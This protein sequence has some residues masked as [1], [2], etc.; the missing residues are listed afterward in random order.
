MKRLVLSI[1]FGA[2]IFIIGCKDPTVT[3]ITTATTVHFSADSLAVY[4][5]EGRTFGNTDSLALPSEIAVSN[6]YIIVGDNIANR[7]LTIFARNTGEYIT[8]AGEKGEGPGEIQRVSYLDFKSDNDIGWVFDF[9]R[10][11]MHYVDIDSLIKSNLT[12]KTVSFTD[13]G[14][15]TSP[16]W[17]TADSIASGG[18]YT[19][20]KLALYSSDGVRHRMV[21]PSPPGKT[22]TPVPVRQHAYQSLLRTN[23][24]GTKIV[25]ASRYTDQVEIYEEN[26]LSYLIR[27]P[28][29][30]DPIYKVYHDDDGNSWLGFTPETVI[31]YTSVS[32]TD[33]LI[34]A[35]YSGAPQQP[36]WGQFT[37]TVIVFTWT[38]QPVA[39]LDLSDGA[40]EIAVSPS[41]R[42]LYAI[43]HDPIPQIIHYTI[44]ELL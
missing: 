39:I 20:G 42:D 40:L 10:G 14:T 13:A 33:L 41:G 28:D 32:A 26:Q 18:F 34:F 24:S 16:V 11:Q 29:I 6:K 2:S 23:M 4:V 22:S 21:G 44:P 36:G 12:G 25:A 15:P 1:G 38:G 8:S 7:P 19:T 3:G 37:R 35:L 17:I 9:S 31:G 43:F 5:L 30:F 27:G